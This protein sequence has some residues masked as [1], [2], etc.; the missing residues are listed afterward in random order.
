MLRVHC[1]ALARVF[2]SLTRSPFFWLCPSTN[3]FL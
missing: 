3:F 1:R 2:D